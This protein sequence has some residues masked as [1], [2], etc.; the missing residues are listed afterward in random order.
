[1]SDGVPERI[2]NAQKQP[3]G[4]KCCKRGW[5][6]FIEEVISIQERP[7]EQVDFIGENTN[8]YQESTL[9]GLKKE[10]A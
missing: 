8:Q 9:N 10:D 5:K 4:S 7:M 3:D 2:C 1:L 6:V